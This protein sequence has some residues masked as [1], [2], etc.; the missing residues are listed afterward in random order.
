[1]VIFDRNISKSFQKVHICVDIGDFVDRFCHSYWSLYSAPLLHSIGS[2]RLLFKIDACINFAS[3]IPK[4]FWP[5]ARLKGLKRSCVVVVV[6]VAR[7][8]AGNHEQNKFQIEKTMCKGTKKVHRGFYGIVWPCMA[9]CGLVW[10]STAIFTLYGV[11]WSF[12]FIY[13]KI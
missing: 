5:R 9:L 4:V 1:M 6:R 2:T 13:G 10:P 7:R 8:L 11:I 3:G 12:M